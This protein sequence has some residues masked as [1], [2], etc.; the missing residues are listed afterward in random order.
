MNTLPFTFAD[1]DLR[2]LPS[3]ALFW[4]DPGCLI[5]ADLHLGKS[6]RVAR[7]GGAALPPYDARETLS[8]LSDDLSATGARQVIC[9]GD[10]FDFLDADTVLPEADLLLLTRMQAGV[11]WVWIAGNHDPGPVNL[12]GSHRA[13]LAQG[14]LVFRHIATPM[15]AAEVSGHY[16]PKVRLAL[17]GRA[18]A[19]PCFLFDDRRL[20]LPAYGAYTGG[21]FVDAPALAGLM[22]PA[23][24]VILTGSAMARL[25]VH[26]LAPLRGTLTRGQ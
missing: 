16:H 18:V 26:R 22:S 12:G 10:S 23:A 13:E 25:P 5:V 14:G 17:R 19:R 6:A 1:A 2:A 21:L 3:G 9:L 11:D 20:I 4:P 15:A 8:R 24:E 7:L